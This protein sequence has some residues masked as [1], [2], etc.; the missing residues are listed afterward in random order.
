MTP[1]SLQG[2]QLH[3]ASSPYLRQHADNP[4]NWQMWTPQTLSSA[5]Q[6]NKPILLSIGYAAC[7]WCHVMAHESF[8][9]QATADVMN[10]LFVNIKIDREER[11]DIDQIYMAAL[12]A[13]GEQ[14]GWPL[15]MFLTSEAVPYWGGTYFPP[16]PSYGRPAFTRVLEALEDSYRKKQDAVTNNSMAIRAHLENLSKHPDNTTEAL[17][18]SLF[19]E[20]SERTLSIFDPVHG[21][22]RGAPKFPNAPILETWARTAG[23]NKGSNAGKAFLHTITKI[24]Q[25]GIYDHLRGGIARYSVDELWLAP[26]FE[27]MLYDNAHYIR[28]LTTAWKL[29]G[30]ELFRQR[31]EET[32]DWLQ[33]EMLLQEGGYAASLDADSEGEEG[34]FYVWSEVEVK[35]E[36]GS[37]YKLFQQIY[38]V[39]S[40][41]NW[42]G[43]NILNR[44]NGAIT[45]S[46]TEKTLSE[47]RSKLL[48]QRNKRIRPGQDDKLLTDWNGY[49]IRA[50]AEAGTVFNKP[51]WVSHAQNAFHFIAESNE[52]D[53]GL[54]HS[55]R[56]GI[57]VK[58]ALATDYGAM[59]NAAL[60]LNEA[61]NDPG[62]LEKVTHWSEI[63]SRD[64]DDG[65]G[66]YFLTSNKSLDLIVRPRCDLDEANPSGASQ[67]LEALIRHAHITGNEKILKAAEELATNQQAVAKSSPGNMAGFMNALQSWFTH[68]HVLIIA[69]NKKAAT[70]LIDATHAHPTL[71]KSIMIATDN[72]R[73]SHLGTTL[74][75]S[76]KKSTAIVCSR[77]SCSA[78]VST[79]DELTALLNET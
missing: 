63:L 71:A 28:H 6:Q 1:S 73:D 12:H 78:P 77:Q 45:N 67:I 34:K 70:K 16:K 15:T 23:S 46:E 65:A 38:N 79:P 2:N 13:M 60:S 24:S 64:Y 61:T 37:D 18:H 41:G 30:K 74:P 4:V 66:G 52:E 10:R 53:G 39:S 8:E 19:I 59:M 54:V 35:K 36:T 58:P 62:Y 49:L 72:N 25:G 44:L 56:K 76:Q 5:K 9:D 55:F 47:L 22:I 7:H 69:K 43:K 51:E 17:D 11:P 50:L 14:G 27:K 21:G 75:A 26:H 33:S 48:E 31:T 32:I 29:S 68:K 40:N 3:K 42:E 20:F 57:T